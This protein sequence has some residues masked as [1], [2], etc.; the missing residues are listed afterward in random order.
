MNTSKSNECVDNCSICCEKFNKSHRKVVT[1]QFCELSACR[2][3][4][5]YY[6]TSTTNLANCMG[7]N[8]PW[9]RKFLQS[10]LTKSYF[11]KGW[12]EHRKTILFETEKARLAEAMPKVEQVI[13]IKKLKKDYDILKTEEDKIL[14]KWRKAKDATAKIRSIMYNIKHI[15]GSSRVFMKRCPGDE[16]NGFLSTG[17]KCGL[18]ELRVCSKCND[19]MGYTA[20]CKD[21][22]ECDPD[23]VAS[24]ELIRDETRPCPQCAAPIFK[25]S[26]C[27]QM[28]C[29]SCNIAF[30]WKSGMK[31]SGT[32][33]NPHY[34]EFMKQ[35][36]GNAVQ[37]PGAVN[38]GGL[39]DYSH[40]RSVSRLC[41]AKLK[42]RRCDLLIGK[43]FALHRSAVH[44]QGVVLDE[45][46]RTIQRNR[47]NEDLR[48]KFIM[49]DIDEEKFKSTLI[50]RDNDFE[51]KQALLYIYELMGNVFVETIIGM[52]NL[53]HTYVNNTDTGNVKITI[54]YCD[55]I[56]VL[57]K[58][59]HRVRLY[60]NK[61]LMNVCIIY[62][63]IVHI[64]DSIFATPKMNT[65][66]CKLLADKKNYSFNVV[67]CTKGLMVQRIKGCG[68]YT[69]NQYHGLDM[70]YS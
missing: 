35:N 22:H 61:E 68:G 52:Y 66:S 3:C 40:M 15:K 24:A 30:S 65:K 21:D 31:V 19:A 38:C 36:G 55:A 20:N 46:R 39:P 28:W 25:I 9:D 34:Y 50:R 32:I 26:G 48:V 37:N 57:F 17:Y 27:D 43:I 49:K 60:C 1:C 11:S 18:C 47:D 58:N 69:R 42:H 53:S 16:C 64:I 5:K 70:V 44:F 12:K 6:L 67:Y 41:T 54:E 59:I 2:T 29:T 63:Q 33:H 7:C 23:M 13:Q 10:S 62:N 51:K 8:K 4:I 14:E 45:T 56:D